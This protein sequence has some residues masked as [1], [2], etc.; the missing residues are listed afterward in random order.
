MKRQIIP[1][2]PS[3]KCRSAGEPALLRLKCKQS[4]MNLFIKLLEAFDQN[5]KEN[6]IFQNLISLDPN[7][8]KQEYTLLNREQ[9]F[10][11]RFKEEQQYE[12]LPPTTNEQG[13][14]E[15]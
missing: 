1:F 8:P 14:T 11:N 9:Q 3:Y 10:I 15:Q 7:Q 4:S 2:T 12:E 6:S 13:G 5:S